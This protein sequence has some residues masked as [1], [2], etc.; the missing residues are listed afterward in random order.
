LRHRIAKTFPAQEGS[1]Q[2][3]GAAMI[4]P[5]T[6]SIVNATFR[7]RDRAI[8]FGVLARLSD[9]WRPSDRW[10]EGWLTTD[11]SWRWAFYINIP[12]GIAVIAGSLLWVSDSRD[13]NVQRGVDPAGIAAISLGL[14]G[15]IFSLIEGSRYG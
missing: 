8:A 2:G 5:S 3:V 15:L 10:S 13:E 1:I 7:G 4:L 6:L 12:I 9:A 14:L 11:Y